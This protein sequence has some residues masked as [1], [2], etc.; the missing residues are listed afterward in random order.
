MDVTE[1][2]LQIAHTYLRKVRKS[3]PENIMAVCPF[4]R[5][6]DGSEETGP[7]FAM[8]LTK[9][10]YFCHSCK[11]KGS[12]HSFLVNIGLD[13]STIKIKYGMVVD[14]AR[15]NIP[16]MPH[17]TQPKSI[18][19]VSPIDDA[20]LGLFDY[21]V[22]SLLP[23][24]TPETLKHFEV[25]WDGWN[26]RITFPI[27][28]VQGHLVG[29]S[30][31]AT[32]DRQ[33]PRYKIYDQEYKIWDL[34]ERIGWN[35]S[36]VVWNAD[37]V[38][39]ELDLRIGDPSETYIAVV[40]GFKA[41][42]WLWQCGVKNVVAML[43]SYLSWEHEWILVH[44]GVPV[45]L[46]LDNNNAGWAGATNAARRLETV[47]TT[48]LV[49]YPDR[50]REDEDAQPDNLT[51]EEVLQQMA[52]APKVSEWRSSQQEEIERWRSEKMTTT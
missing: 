11:A 14:E 10:V 51:A 41:A 16:P 52:S 7:S 36:S 27:R 50:L 20:L 12:L 31:R 28:N 39:P 26:R 24:F 34:P 5:K 23:E 6:A 8:S 29:I 42:M 32:L 33:I 44:L 47:L 43:G 21:D 4:H 22:S 2:I 40:E 49:M 25:G 9:G 38:Y 18:F 17:A 46:F 13:R 19:D 30:G 35:K 37:R 48:R 15:K 3:G 1:N 45:Y